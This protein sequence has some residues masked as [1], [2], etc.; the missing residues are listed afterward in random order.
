MIQ[1]GLTYLAYGATL[2]LLHP[3]IAAV[4]AFCVIFRKWSNNNRTP[5]F[6]VLN[7]LFIF[8]EAR[9]NGQHSAKAVAVGVV[10]YFLHV[11]LILAWF[12]K[13]EWMR[14]HILLNLVGVY[15]LFSVFHVYLLPALPADIA[16]PMRIGYHLV[17]MGFWAVFFSLM[18]SGHQ[19]S[20]WWKTVWVRPFWFLWVV[21]FW[22]YSRPIDSV[23][24]PVEEKSFGKDVHFL[25]RFIF[26][27]AVMTVFEN[28][29]F[30][31]AIL[32]PDLPFLRYFEFPI[33]HRDGFE[34]Y[35]TPRFS[36]AD[37][38]SGQ[39]LSTIHYL[40]SAF[41]QAEVGINFAR[42]WG[43]PLESHV[44]DFWNA[45]NFTDFYYRT[46]H[47]YALL[48]RRVIF[49]VRRY[50]PRWKN[51]PS[52]SYVVFA[53]AFFVSSQI[54]MYIGRGLYLDDT[55]G[56]TTRFLKSVENYQYSAIM[57]VLCLMSLILGRPANSR[58]NYVKIAGFFFITAFA[59]VFGF[60]YLATPPE[61]KVEFIRKA[62]GN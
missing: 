45:R 11:F 30:R 19:K 27:F 3:V 41:L 1:A 42:I 23:V 26:I 21:P 56:T 57:T 34:A 9:L 49:Y 35:L 55:I 36:R 20:L 8:L 17:L 10:Y 51:W 54:N 58:V 43:I 31:H 4:Y 59:L 22:H 40:F 12:E 53:G 2:Y 5:V 62:F 25:L 52:F 39:V 15:V 37:V 6:L 33:T 60:H 16:G 32:T 13:S 38:I 14:R 48:L 28:V 61:V 46:A 24:E 44:Q 50:F 29:F 7:V 47:Y 18:Y